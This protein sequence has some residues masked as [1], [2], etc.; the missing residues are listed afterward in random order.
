MKSPEFPLQFYEEQIQ[1]VYYY[2]PA[3]TDAILHSFQITVFWDIMPRK[4]C[5]S[6]LKMEAAGSSILSEFI[7]QCHNPEDCNLKIYSCDTSNLTEDQE[8]HKTII[9]SVVPL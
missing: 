2:Y 7:H 3:Q 1:D 5:T 4:L 8:T 9:L 6:I